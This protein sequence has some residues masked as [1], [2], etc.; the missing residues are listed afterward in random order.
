MYRAWNTSLAFVWT[1]TVVLAVGLTGCATVALDRSKVEPLKSVDLVRVTTPPLQVLTFTQAMV[2]S[3]AV[4]A[5][6]IPAAIAEAEGNTLVSPPAIPDLG[7]LV[8][9]G[10]RAKLP[11]QAPWWPKMIEGQGGAVA[12]AYKHSG[13]PWLRVEVEK[14][15][16]A[17]PP[18]RTVY[19]IVDVSLRTPANEPIWVERKA[20]SGAVHGGEKIDVNRI[21][22]DLTQLRREVERAAQWL[23]DEVVAKVR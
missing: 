6:L 14:F 15:E 3:P 11:G 19:A 1:I 5:G 17:P 22:G 23:V 18:F 10:L 8:S 4:G 21:P 9:D 12:K 13:G 2:N 20:F 7:V 16:V